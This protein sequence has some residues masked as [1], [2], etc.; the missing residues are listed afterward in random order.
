MNSLP[1]SWSICDTQNLGSTSIKNWKVDWHA[2]KN[3]SSADLSNY[4]LHSQES[5]NDTLIRGCNNIIKNELEHLGF[6]SLLIG[7]EAIL[8]LKDNP[9]Q[10]RSMRDLIRRGKRYGKVI[11]IPYSEIN[12]NKLKELK[13]V[14]VHGTEPQL[15]NLFQME[16]K[17]N[18]LLYVFVNSN[19]NWLGAILLSKNSVVKLH[20]E[21]L[22]RK[23]NAPL[24]V[25]ETLIENI[26]LEAKN[27]NF[28]YLSLGEVPYI[29]P[30]YQNG[31]I[32]SKLLYILGK[33]LSF[34]Y[35]SEGLYNFKNK[36]NPTWS[37]VYICTS[38][39]V[40]LKHLF[41]IVIHSNFHKLVLYKL[42][43]G[44]KNRFYVFFPFKEKKKCTTQ[45]DF[46]KT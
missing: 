4:N 26:F 15:K 9:F 32:Y 17:S 16:F 35:N 41:F 22:L 40:S 21:L 46:N 11:K 42:I 28:K 23:Q 5:D 39:K 1:L 6:S 10:K 13:K 34:A 3:I 36:F 20:T 14:S 30:V 44:L 29:K 7:Y 43:Y 8:D 27:N 38:K 2:I 25:M 31:N 37:K 45:L 18:N 33:Y 24:G 12:K 19:N